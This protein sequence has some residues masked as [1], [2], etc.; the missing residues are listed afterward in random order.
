[1][2]LL[3]RYYNI[4]LLG[5]YSII[6]QI[7]IIREIFNTFSGNELTA[8]LIL[9]LWLSGSGLGNLF[10]K[11]LYYVLSDRSDKLFFLNLTF[12]ILNVLILRYFYSL[13]HFSFG[14]L[15]NI[16]YVILYALFFIVPLSFLWGVHFNYF[17]ISIKKDEHKESKIY[18]V[19]S[20]GAASGAFFALFIGIRLNSIFLIITVLILFFIILLL[21]Q[22]KTKTVLF[23]ITLALLVLFSIFHKK[24]D[25]LTDTQ[26][27][28]DLEVIAIEE[29]PYGKLS[30]IKQEGKYL[31]FYQNGVLLFSTSDQLSPQIDVSLALSQAGSMESILLINNGIAGI[32]KNV[33]IY[34]QV[35][36]ITYLEFNRFLLE[37]Y[38]HYTKDQTLQD[39]RLQV[40]IEDPRKSIRRMRKKF[41]IIFLNNGDPYNMQG[42][43]YFTIE[44]FQD[45]KKILAPGG[46][47]FFK[48]TSSENFINRYQSLYLGSLVNTLKTVFEDTMVIP[49]DNCYLLASNRKNILTYDVQKILEKVKKINIRSEFFRYY[50]LKFNMDPFRIHTFIN[51]INRN[52]KVNQ[53]LSP[54]CFFYNLMLWTTRTSQTIKNIFFFFYHVKF[55]IV[56]LFFLVLI[57]SLHIKILHSSKNMIL[58]SMGAIG[59]TEISLEI[60]SI[61]MYQIIRGDL[62]LNMSFIFLSFMIGLAWGSYLFKK[63]K[64]NTEKLFLMIQFLFIFIPMLLLLNYFLIKMIPSTWIQDMLFFLFIFGFSILSGIQFPAAVRLFE[65]STFGVGKINGV[66]LICAGAGAFIISLFILP[67]FGIFYSIILLCLINLLAFVSIIKLIKH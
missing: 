22:K 8:G 23:Y 36:H 50:F 52:A 25:L 46:I 5:F 26:R 2:L 14:E 47:I 45:L 66:D 18:T 1:M 27:F 20:A 16:L 54:I 32:L 33:V 34:T 35:K 3:R 43:R 65:D 44:F 4:F 56:L 58:L 55:Y 30:T 41:D 19:E 31:S 29:T 17:Y 53:D 6:C 59:F 38:R 63:L 24:I 48:V 51:S 62:Y 37:H 42:N 39:K 21:L 15:I 60:L 13:F 7:F 9:A 28:Q 49:G 67:L 64:I 12:F 10:S 61:L 11:K 57:G 40:M